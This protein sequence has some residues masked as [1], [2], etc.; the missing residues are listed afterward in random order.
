[1]K[2]F[3]LILQLLCFVDCNV[4]DK[5]FFLI[6]PSNYGEKPYIVNAY[7]PNSKLL[8]INT[9]EGDNGSIIE[10]KSVS[11]TVIQD[12]SSIIIIKN[13][14]IIKTCFGPNK[15]VEIINEKN[16]AFLHENNNS[17]K[18]LANIKFCYSSEVINPKNE[19]EFLI[20]T[21]WTE[22]E[23]K[24]GLEIFSHRIILFDANKNKFSEE[25]TLKTNSNHN[26]YTEKCTTLKNTDIYC[27][28]YINYNQFQLQQGS[29]LIEAKNIF[30]SENVIQI[31]SR[32]NA[33]NAVILK[34]LISMGLSIYDIIGSIYQVFLGL[35]FDKT[36]NLL[37]LV[38]NNFR[39]SQ[40]LI[41]TQKLFSLPFIDPALF[42]SLYDDDIS[43][44]YLYI[45]QK[46]N[47]IMSRYDLN[48]SKKLNIINDL[49]F[50]NYLRDDICKNPKFMQSIFIN[51]LI[52]Y[53]KADQEYIKNNG[54]TENF[55]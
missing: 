9:S 33:N 48:Y 31:V 47:L 26:F 50:P 10:N 14:L 40:N 52:N 49:F 11:E 6:Y 44:I 13:K 8:E 46:K 39:K 41:F 16:E 17:S 23:V 12:L 28:I 1:M 5:Y 25:I 51:S 36:K 30:K 32:N 22:F 45:D 27:D 24:N 29:F 34:N 37:S 15:I 38:K 43:L 55:Y 20:L 18:N 21:Y 54:G 4:D 53:N 35:T 7:I 2:Y 19:G 42:N 3:L